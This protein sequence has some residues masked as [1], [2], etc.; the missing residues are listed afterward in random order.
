[1]FFT[2]LG[3]GFVILAG[4]ERLSSIDSNRRMG[5]ERT[6]RNHTGRIQNA[7]RKLFPATGAVT[8]AVL[9]LLSV[10]KAP[11]WAQAPTAQSPAAPQWQTD[12]GG[13]MEFDVASVKQN[14]S[15]LP[16]SGNLP[17]S[18]IP[19]GP[20]DMYAPTGGLLSATNWRLIQY[21]IFAYKLTPDQILSV[22]S[23]LPKW[24]TTDRYDIQARASGNPTKDQF[25]LMTQAL[26]ADRFKL[27][28]RYETR[29]L[30]VF[31]LVL[32]KP[33][34][35][36]THIQLHPEDSPCSSAPPAPGSASDL[37]ATVAGGFPESCGSFAGWLAPNAPGRV[38]VGARNV[39]MAMLATSF[40]VPFTG[41]DRPILDK[42]GL[43]GKFDFVIEFTPQSN[44]F[45]PPGS[46]FRPDESGPTFFEALKEQLGLKLDP[47]KGP[48]DV[49]V[50]DHVEQPSEN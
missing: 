41:V 23:Q 12:A 25:R 2:F 40:N 47:Q 49:V 11:A 39:P 37:P 20:Q 13:K 1:M 9:V 18:N 17:Y 8:L 44:G 43:A 30:P 5:M 29:Q 28:I 35:L 21:V 24:A 48:V 32:D 27:A 46:E 19:L 38:R 36:G 45:S 22:Q 6:L 42:T 3:V 14:K 16:P 33:G 34:K 4:F 26:L 15:G 10:L 7:W 31:V 50:V